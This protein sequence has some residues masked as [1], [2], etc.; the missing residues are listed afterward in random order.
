MR[1]GALAER[2]LPRLAGRGIEPAEPARRLRRVPDASIR[3]WGYV[4]WMRARRDVV[5]GQFGL[6]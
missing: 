6:P 1:R 4:M 5:D 2:N 3:G